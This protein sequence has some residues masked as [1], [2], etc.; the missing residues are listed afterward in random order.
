MRGLQGFATEQQIWKQYTITPG[1]AKA[2]TG[3]HT[4]K[5][6]GESQCG[7]SAT[8]VARKSPQVRGRPL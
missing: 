4:L 6:K 3:M 2:K 8:F 1:E 7:R 5:R